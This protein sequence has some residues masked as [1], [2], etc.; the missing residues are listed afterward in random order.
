M[1]LTKSVIVRN[2]AIQSSYNLLYP[3]YFAYLIC[4]KRIAYMGYTCFTKLAEK[5]KIF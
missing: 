1:V 3:V 5:V 2:E 4:M